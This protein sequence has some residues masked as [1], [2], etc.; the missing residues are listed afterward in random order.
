MVKVA[1]D[2]FFMTT[3]GQVDKIIQPLKDYFGLTSFVY[4]KS[5]NDGSEIRLSNQ[6]EWLSYFYE[7]ELYKFSLFERHPS[8]YIKAYVPWTG[9]TIYNTVL[10][11][12]RQFNID[13]GITFIEPCADG[14]EFFFIG[15]KVD[16]ADVMPK[17]L[18]NIDLLRRFLDHFREKAG[19][20]IQEASHHK[21]TIPGKFDAAPKLFCLKELNRSGFL[22]E[23]D[24]VEFTARELECMRL[25]AKGY[26][27]KMIA[28]EL[29]ISIRT[30]ETHLNHVKDKTH[31]HSRGELVQYLLKLHL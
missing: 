5:F 16:R 23:P 15:T 30:V 9:L 26:T 4:L 14:C 13:H 10:E 19:P 7:H 20:L 22:N 17:Y 27:Q 8:E 6:P 1:G 18:A 28:K 24:F 12:A 29:D 31:T 21:I 3:S 2:H 25:L 11:K